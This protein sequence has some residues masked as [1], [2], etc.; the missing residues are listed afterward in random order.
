MSTR[1]QREIETPFFPFLSVIIGVIGV[2][3]LVIVSGSY[4]GI[5]KADQYVELT[6][7]GEREK[8]RST[9]NVRKKGS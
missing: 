5:R 8:S 7:T 4:S 6:P 1:R 2:L 9:S 3:L